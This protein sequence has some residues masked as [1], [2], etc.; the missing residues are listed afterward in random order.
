MLR[1]VQ[2]LGSLKLFGVAV[3]KLVAVVCV[4]MFAP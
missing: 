2:K 3:A 4:P 1:D